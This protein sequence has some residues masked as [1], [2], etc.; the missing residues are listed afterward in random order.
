MSAP[1]YKERSLDQGRLQIKGYTYDLFLYDQI[2]HASHHWPDLYSQ[3]IYLSIPY[4]KVMEK[5]GL[6][7]V[8]PYYALLVNG[9]EEIVAC[10]YFQVTLFQADR[11]I[12]LSV[13]KE[14]SKLQ[15]LGFLLKKK[16]ANKLTFRTLVLGNLSVSGPYGQWFQPSFKGSETMAIQKVSQFVF[17]QLREI[18]PDLR[19][20]L[21]KDYYH[22]LD[23]SQLPSFS[24]FQIQ[25]AMELQL[26]PYWK[27][28]GDYVRDLRSK[29]RVRYRKA[30]ERS[31]NLQKVTYS[32][33]R[34]DQLPVRRIYQLYSK[35]AENANFNIAT[36]DE[37][38]FKELYD[39]LCESTSTI[40]YYLKGELVAFMSMVRDADRL[41]AQF[42]GYEETLNQEHDLYLNLLYDVIESGIQMGCKKI[43][44]ARTALEIKSSVGARPNELYCYLHY[45]SPASQLFVPSL[46]KYLEPAVD[47]NQRSPLKREDAG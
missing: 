43:S 29:Y 26:R 18:Y 31:T 27:D 8:P 14:I 10:F 17:K 19:A 24:E 45:D 25:P 11:S 46:I 4:L 33:V 34:S 35:R 21:L 3:R 30:R 1:D 23:T 22:S 41:D 9:K 12:Q 16:L 38:Y 15:K 20:I 47:W 7:Q 39:H 37:E 44:F 42:T 5:S 40:T 28:F 32:Q 36:L 13:Q 6:Q 2:E